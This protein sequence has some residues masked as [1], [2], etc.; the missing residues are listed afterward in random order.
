[1]GVRRL[2]HEQSGKCHVQACA[3]GV[4]GVTGGTTRPTRALEHPSVSSLAMRLGSAGSE[5]LVASTRRISS[6]RNQR[7]R[8]IPKLASRAMPPSTTSTKRKDVK[9]GR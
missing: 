5:E 9:I 4:E 6:R 2:G 1:M 3:V 7:K 8:K